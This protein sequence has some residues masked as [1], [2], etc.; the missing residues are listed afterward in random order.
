VSDARVGRSATIS[1]LGA[2]FVGGTLFI[3][4]ALRGT[5]QAMLAYLAAFGFA[6]TTAIGGLST[7]MI[8]YVV[9]ARWFVVLRRLTEAISS[10]VATLLLFF[11]PIAASLRVLYSWAQPAR[12]L[13]EAEPARRATLLGQSWLSPTWFVVRGVL[14]LCVWLGLAEVLRRGSL[15]QDRAQPSWSSRQRLALSAVGIPVLGL[16]ATFATFDWL[17]SAVPGWNMTGVGLYVLTGGFTSSVG[18]L[19][20]LLAW[21]RRRDLLPTEVGAAHAHAVGRLLLSGVCLWAYL[22]ISQLI[23][24]WSANLPRESAFYL[25]RTPGPWRYVAGLLVAGHFVVP[26][27]LLLSRTLK[28]RPGFVA[29]LGGWLVLM[30]AIDLYWLIVPGSGRRPSVLDAGPFMLLGGVMAYVGLSRFFR[31]PAVPQND[32]DLERSLRYESP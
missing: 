5:Q 17:M 29:V 16:S 4:A 11:I 18:I 7:L 23:I 15:A 20:V 13:T 19:A 14:Y 10:T 31:A 3:L 1:A 9:G 8:G 21:A 6:F 24:V 26:F 25:D 28:R 27:L 2:V 22:G 12:L 30:H 32:P